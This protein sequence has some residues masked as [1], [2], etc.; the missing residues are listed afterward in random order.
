[1]TRKIIMLAI[2]ATALATSAP[3]LASTI[4]LTATL[5]GAAETS[6]GDPDG[7]GSF[8]VE[9]DPDAG[10]FCYTLKAGSIDKVT[11]AHVHEGV[12]G[13]NGGPVITLDVAEDMC[14][15]V[16]P[17]KLKPIVENP[18]GFYVNV[19]TVAFPAGAVRGQLAKQ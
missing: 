6:G 7:T 17:D 11:M 15:A 12:A 16:E 10:D 18:A 5:N 1:M 13:A 19:H 4:T 2:S 3:V 14:I 8:M 9:I